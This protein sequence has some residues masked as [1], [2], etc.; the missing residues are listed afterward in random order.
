MRFPMDQRRRYNACARREWVC[1]SPTRARSYAYDAYPVC[2]VAG[3]P[4]ISSAPYSTH[5]RPTQ[6]R[7]KAASG[8][9]RALGG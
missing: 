9:F 7:E 4:A 3:G 5:H 2:G 1:A 6:L 8:T